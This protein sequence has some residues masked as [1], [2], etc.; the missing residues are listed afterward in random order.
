ME[1]VWEGNPFSVAINR[2]TIAARGRLILSTEYRTNIS[3]M[4]PTLKRQRVAKGSVEGHVHVRGR[5]FW[6]RMHRQ[7][8][9]AGLAFGDVDAVVKASLD[10]LEKAGVIL[11]DAQAV[12]TSF[13]KHYDKERPRIELEVRPWEVE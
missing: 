7:G 1:Y 10:A 5:V 9:A 12:A 13:T 8:P 2:R 4:V 11:S 3:R 6:K